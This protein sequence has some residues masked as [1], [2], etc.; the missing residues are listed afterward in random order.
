MVRAT[1]STSNADILT[2]AAHFFALADKAV[3]EDLFRRA[4]LSDPEDPGRW[5]KLGQHFLL[6]LQSNEFA[7]IK[8]R[9]K[10]ADRSAT[11]EEQRTWSRLGT[12]AQDSLERALSLGTPNVVAVTWDAARAALAARNCEEAS[13]LGGRLLEMSDPELR[14]GSPELRGHLILG[15]VEL[16]Y[17]RIAAASHHLI[18]ATKT[19]TPETPL[20]PPGMR[21]ALELF[22][23]GQHAVV[24]TYLEFCADAW[25]L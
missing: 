19:P 2:N 8:E 23:R 18:D 9:S 15:R 3:A 24:E 7:Y 21:L 17:G 6:E 25:P 16:V 12:S 13:K 5:E 1:A 14:E 20:Q 4:V 22:W 11:D 10:N